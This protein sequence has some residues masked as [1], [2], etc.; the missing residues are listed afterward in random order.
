[1]SILETFTILPDCSN[2]WHSFAATK[3][4][5]IKTMQKKYKS[6]AKKKE[7]I[8]KAVQQ[9]YD[10]WLYECINYPRG[11]A[12]FKPKKTDREIERMPEHQRWELGESDMCISANT[13]PHEFGSE[14]NK[15]ITKR[16]K[17]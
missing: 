3:Q 4:P 8:K 14:Y 10:R 9:A 1:M 2:N 16:I 15:Y 17:K 13:S 11:I 6:R 7:A 12:N 5:V